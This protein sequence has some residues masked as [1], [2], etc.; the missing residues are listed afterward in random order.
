M[1]G[2]AWD[3]HRAGRFLRQRDLPGAARPRPAYRQPALRNPAGL[4]AAGDELEIAASIAYD[5]PLCR[6]FKMSLS[7]EAKL[8]SSV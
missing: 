4:V 3:I 6:Y 5:A 2:R 8:W 7:R 1:G